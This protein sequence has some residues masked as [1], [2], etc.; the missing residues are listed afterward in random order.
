MEQRFANTKQKPLRLE[1]QGF[2]LGNHWIPPF[3][4]RAGETIC[5]HMPPTFVS[6]QETL[7]PLFKGT[8]VHP[9]LQFHGSAVYLERPT[10]Q[11]GWFGRRKD[12]SAYDWLTTKKKLSPEEATAVL[13]RVG[14]AGD[15]RIG[16][17]GWNER[18]LLALEAFLNRPTDVLV[19]D[20]AGNDPPGIRRVF[21]RLISRPENLALA[22]LKTVPNLT[23]CFPGG[24]CLE[25]P[26]RPMETAL[27]E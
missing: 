14:V 12:I 19:F 15:L 5:L 23:P 22:Y 1:C 17:M 4:L 10:P 13:E 2:F 25:I 3:Q 9:G 24:W 18:T 6:W 7:V 27:V 11:R 8:S 26:V 20:T 16:W 21:D